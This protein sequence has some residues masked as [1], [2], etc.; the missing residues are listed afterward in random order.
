MFFVQFC[1]D[2]DHSEPTELTGSM[3][4]LDMGLKYFYM[5]SGGNSMPCP[6]FLQKAE[7]RLS[8]EQRRECG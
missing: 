4:G 7:K 8:R 2:V 1:V 3:V 5:D 6:K